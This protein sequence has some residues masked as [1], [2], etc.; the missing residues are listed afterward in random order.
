M[1]Y[2]C[3]CWETHDDDDEQMKVIRYSNT[4]ATDASVPNHVNFRVSQ[5]L[6]WVACRKTGP[7]VSKSFWDTDGGTV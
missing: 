3:L 2:Y 5:A 6:S 1:M 7:R 4:H